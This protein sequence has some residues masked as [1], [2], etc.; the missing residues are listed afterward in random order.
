MRLL[1]HL[2]A[3]DR[4]AIAGAAGTGKTVLAME[5]A[6]RLALGGQRA[7]VLCFNMPLAGELASVGG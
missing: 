7:L 3:H 5:R 2:A 4:A 1:D 6:R